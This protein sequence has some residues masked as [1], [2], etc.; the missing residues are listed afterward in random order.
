MLSIDND[1]DRFPGVRNVKCRRAGCRVILFIIPGTPSPGSA[2]YIPS[3]LADEMLIP[4]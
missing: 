1:F 2:L 4:R 3:A